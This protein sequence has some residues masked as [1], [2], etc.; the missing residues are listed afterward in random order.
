L[1]DAVVLKYDLSI[2]KLPHPLADKREIECFI[3]NE[4]KKRDIF[5]GS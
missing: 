1:K 5:L 2:E 4:Q 3:G